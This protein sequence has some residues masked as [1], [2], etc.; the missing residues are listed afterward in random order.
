[1]RD[2]QPAHTV[3]YTS[4]QWYKQH[5][6][7]S[8]DINKY[9]PT[10]QFLNP[11]R[12]S[13]QPRNSNPQRSDWEHSLTLGGIQHQADCNAKASAE[14]REKCLASEIRKSLP[15]IRVPSSISSDRH[16]EMKR[17]LELMMAD[18]WHEITFELVYKAR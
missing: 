15:C 13:L 1:M 3:I 10:Y 17:R 4:R 7:E 5:P 16:K 12:R 8:I 6:H 18:K 14:G 2:I 11:R 9:S